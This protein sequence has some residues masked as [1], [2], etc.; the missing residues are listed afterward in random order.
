MTS[1]ESCGE[2]FETPTAPKDNAQV[3]ITKFFCNGL[4]HQTSIEKSHNKYAR[5]A[6]LL[7]RTNNGA[8]LCDF[9]GFA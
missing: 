6:M 7:L 1:E 3:K 8:N 9:G 2:A 4:L 5:V